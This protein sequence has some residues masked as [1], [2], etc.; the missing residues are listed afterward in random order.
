MGSMLPYI[1]APWIRH[2]ICTGASL[3]LNSCFS[4]ELPAK[5]HESYRFHSPVLKVCGP[6]GCQGKGKSRNYVQRSPAAI[7]NDIAITTFFI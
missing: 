7:T 5:N 4:E 1:A 2:G 3:H 6:F